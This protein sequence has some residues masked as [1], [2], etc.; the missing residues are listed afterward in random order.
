MMRYLETGKS[1][2]PLCEGLGHK[3]QSWPWKDLYYSYSNEVLFMDHKD[4]VLKQI[5][6]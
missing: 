6:Y 1:L 3:K 5:L 4:Y 2:L